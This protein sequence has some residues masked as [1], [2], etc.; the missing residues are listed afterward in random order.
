MNLARFSFLTPSY[1]G[2]FLVSSF[3]MIKLCQAAAVFNLIRI[4]KLD[5]VAAT[6]ELDLTQYP[7]LTWDDHFNSISPGFTLELLAS[8]NDRSNNPLAKM[9]CAA[10]PKPM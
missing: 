7:A 9:L 1:I 10:L 8:F 6:S 2:L 4:N 3:S 5:I